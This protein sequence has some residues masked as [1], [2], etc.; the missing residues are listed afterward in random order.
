[1]PIAKLLRRR[2]TRVM[3]FAM[4]EFLEKRGPN[5]VDPTVGPKS[6][7]LMM[8]VAWVGRNEFLHPSIERFGDLIRFRS[9]N[10][11]LAQ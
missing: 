1:M 7:Q 11:R 6:F 4:Q 10:S 3:V 2:G 8:S 5:L 9:L